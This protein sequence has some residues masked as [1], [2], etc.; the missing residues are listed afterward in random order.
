MLYMTAR[1]R[2]ARCVYMY[3]YMY[4]LCVSMCASVCLYKVFV[5]KPQISKS[6][7]IVLVSSTTRHLCGA[8]KVPGVWSLCLPELARDGR[9]LVA[10]QPL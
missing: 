1:A 9:L 2:S 4:M 7:R 5:V 10:G 8:V 6:V 3:M